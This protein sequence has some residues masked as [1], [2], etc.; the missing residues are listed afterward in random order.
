MEPTGPSQPPK[1]AAYQT[2]GVGV[3]S[4]PAELRSARE[5]PH[6]RIV[7]ERIPT[8]QSSDTQE[9]TPTSMARG[10]RGA[11]PGEERYKTEEQVGRHRELE[12]EQMRAP[13]EGDVADAVDRKPGA[14]GSQP[15]LASDL[16]RYVCTNG[17][18]LLI[19]CY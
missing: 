1:A 3:E 2:E 16:D 17:G 5:H 9:A 8:T 11:P 13:G 15:D 12:G 7:E 18:L 10:I 4:T 19:F 14:S 6:G